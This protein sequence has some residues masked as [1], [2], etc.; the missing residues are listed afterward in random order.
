M[1]HHRYIFALLL[2]L[3]PAVFAQPAHSVWSNKPL[4]VYDGATGAHFSAFVRGN[5]AFAWN[6]G[7][8]TA[9][10]RAVGVIN[11]A[12]TYDFR[13]VSVTSTSISEISGKF[14]IFKNGAIVCHLCIGK[15]YLLDQPPLPGKYFK[16][17]VGTPVA[18]AEKWHYSGYITSRFDF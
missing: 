9:Y 16:I 7:T 4:Y 3:A 6:Q 8:T 11:A 5:A 2:L 1:K 15:A 13:L 12:L 10:A 18:Y 14:D 17:Y